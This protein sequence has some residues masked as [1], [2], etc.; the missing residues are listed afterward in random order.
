MRRDGPGANR[1]GMNQPRNH[2]LVISALMGS[3]GPLL[4]NGLYAGAES[5]DGKVILEEF[6]DGLPTIGYLAFTLELLGFAALA[7]FISC[8]VVRIFTV[9]P[10]AAA[11]AGI[12]GSA[13]I[14][15]KIGSAAPWMA[16]IADADTMDPDLAA[17]LI[18]VNDMG[19]NVS[20][21]LLSLSFTAAGIGLLKTDTA[22]FLAWW[23]T[24]IGP[25]GI[26][27]G[28]VGVASPDD[29]LPIPFLLLLVWMIALAIATTMR[30]TTTSTNT[31][32]PSL[33]HSTAQE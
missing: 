25:L 19:F 6:R 24:I 10:V 8:L 7:V 2:T 3:L 18:S 14:A 1:G 29:Y 32:N 26:V 9:A 30:P 5:S 22:R 21:L 27:A 13:M 11:T 15:V 33:S 20:G 28:V 16:V 17:A 12:A 4:G 31:A 23:P